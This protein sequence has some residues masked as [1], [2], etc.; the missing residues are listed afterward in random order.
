MQVVALHQGEQQPLAQAAAIGAEQQAQARAHHRQQLGPGSLA[1]NNRQQT[2]Q[3]LHPQAALGVEQHLQ[4]LLAHLGGVAGQQPPG[5]VGIGHL[6]D[7][8]GGIQP[9]RQPLLAHHRADDQGEARRHPEGVVVHQLREAVGDRLEVEVAHVFADGSTQHL[10]EGGDDL[11]EIGAGVEEA[12]GHE[13]V[14]QGAEIAVDQV[15]HRPGEGEAVGV[16]DRIHHAEIHVAHMAHGAGAARQGEQVAG[17]GIGVEVAELQQLAQAGNHAGADQGSRVEPLRLQRLP[18]LQ[19]GAV[20]P[21]GG[22]HPLAAQVA[23]HC[24]HGHLRVAREQGGEALG[25][26]GLAAVVDLLEQGAAEFVDDLPQP[27]AQVER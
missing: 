12:Q 27:E 6:Q 15:H 13:I 16:A 19:L 3:P 17:V 9:H 2:L 26:V 5:H 14:G 21:G 24:R 4:Q 11:L 7:P 25:I 22:E 1:L 20:Q 18:F 23:L 8:E 10:V